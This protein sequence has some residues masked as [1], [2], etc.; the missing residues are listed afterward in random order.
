VKSTNGMHPCAT[1]QPM[2]MATLKDFYES[3]PMKSLTAGSVH[4]WWTIAKK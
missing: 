1:Q 4:A 3:W 2:P